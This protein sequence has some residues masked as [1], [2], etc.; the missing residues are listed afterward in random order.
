MAACG[1]GYARGA[2][3]THEAQ[4]IT[5][6]LELLHFV[7]FNH[8]NFFFSLFFWLMEAFHLDPICRLNVGILASSF[9]GKRQLS[10]QVREPKSSFRAFTVR[11]KMPQP[12]GIDN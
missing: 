11:S 6:I 2:P 8:F 10:L 3:V 12:H 4:G 9:D 5:S 7:V 1:K